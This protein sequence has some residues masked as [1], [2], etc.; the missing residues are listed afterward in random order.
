MSEAERRGN[1]TTEESNEPSG[2][3]A[4]VQQAQQTAEKV[5]QWFPVRVFQRF[6]RRNGQTLA[7]GVSYQA[8]FAIFAA[9]Y[10]AFAVA[11]LWLGSNAA[12]IDGLIDVIN[13]YLP[14][15]ITE[16]GGIISADAVHDVASQSATT[17][18]VTG[19]VALVVVLF[20][21]VGWIGAI[22][23]TVRDIFGLPNET[24]NA[25]LLKVRDLLAAI[26][27]AV[28]LLIGAVLGWGTTS[29]FSWLFSLLQ[30]TDDGWLAFVSRVVSI[31]VLFAVN[32][33]TLVVLFRFLTATSLS[34]RHVLPGALLGG[35][36][37]AVLQLAF[38]FLIGKTPSNPLLVT[39]AVLIGLLLWIRFVMVAILLAA[40]W[41]AE[42][43]DDNDVVIERVGAREQ[44]IQD[45]L[46]LV[47]AAQLELTEARGAVAEAGFWHRRPARRDVTRAQE[48]LELRQQELEQLEATPA[49]RITARQRIEQTLLREREL[50]R[51]RDGSSSD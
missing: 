4:V 46:V 22:R 30:W 42:S 17:L 2:P 23:A 3:A 6:S 18:G 20:T 41:V 29:A 39:F 25:I 38:G 26:G 21:A 37:V 12:A 40:A 15:A 44:R 31:A 36:A 48:K 9:L 32:T 47:D 28:L 14:G 1:A 35:G 5:M 13:Q 10:L 34:N 16:R 11:G 33:V 24:G 45:A 43:A 50:K 49:E 7:A 51:Q 8:L 27:F 19:I